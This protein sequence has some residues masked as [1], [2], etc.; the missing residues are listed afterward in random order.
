MSDWQLLVLGHGGFII[1][2]I[3]KTLFYAHFWQ[4][5]LEPQVY[6][7]SPQKSDKKIFWLAQN[8]KETIS[9]NPDK[10]RLYLNRTSVWSEVK[11]WSIKNL[12]FVASSPHRE[13]VCSFGTYN[14]Y[15]WPQ[16]SLSFFSVVN[17]WLSKVW[18]YSTS[19]PVNNAVNQVGRSLR[20]VHCET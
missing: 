11:H 3:E 8:N 2:F 18:G 12:Q 4:W 16:E 14:R 17:Q 1:N 19:Q 13:G 10:C 9:K 7:L 6:I 20:G 15:A 5:P